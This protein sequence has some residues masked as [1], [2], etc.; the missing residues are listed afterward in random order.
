VQDTTDDKTLG[1]DRGVESSVKEELAQFSNSIACWCYIASSIR[2][3]RQGSETII[4]ATD[5]CE[6]IV[7]ARTRLRGWVDL[8][9]TTALR[10][11]GASNGVA[12]MV[13]W[14]C[15]ASNPTSDSFHGKQSD[16]PWIVL[17]SKVME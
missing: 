1:L 9:G 12:A 6:P 5:T 2:G 10:C 15:A 16:Y 13:N 7:V 14:A 4:C 17:G 3:T 11:D 8:D